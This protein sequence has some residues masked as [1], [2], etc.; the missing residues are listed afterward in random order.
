MACSAGGANGLVVAPPEV[1]PGAGH[2]MVQYIIT[3]ARLNFP[4]NFFPLDR[5]IPFFVFGRLNFNLM[6]PF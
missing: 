4:F 6:F 3:E 2:R 5:K 1:C